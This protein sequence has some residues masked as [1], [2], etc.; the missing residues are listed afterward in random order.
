M[1]SLSKKLKPAQ[2]GIARVTICQFFCLSDILALLVY[3]SSMMLPL[4]FKMFKILLKSPQLTVTCRCN[5]GIWTS[6]VLASSFLAL[7][8]V[9][10]PCPWPCLRT[11]RP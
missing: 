3:S 2:S 9:P 11:Q 10:C 1:K 4:T 6:L 7:A 5:S 8:F